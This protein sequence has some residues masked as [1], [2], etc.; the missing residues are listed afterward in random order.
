MKPGGLPRQVRNS[1]VKALIRNGWLFVLFFYLV[2]GCSPGDKVAIKQVTFG[3][4]AMAIRLNRKAL[5]HKIGIWEGKK[6]VA[7]KK[8]GKEAKTF[9]V[10]INW[11]RGKKYRIKV[12]LRRQPLPLVATWQAPERPGPLVL[13]SFDLENVE[14]HQLWD[15]CYIG[16][17]VAISPEAKYLAVGSEKGYLRLVN[18]KNGRLL[19]SKRIGEGRIVSMGFSPDGRYLAMGEQSRDAFIYLYDIA[20]CLIWKF[21]AAR[22][23]GTIRPGEPQSH[24]PVVNALVFTPDGKNW[25]I[26]FTAGHY[27]G[28][29]GRNYR[30]RGRV[31]C[32]DMQGHQLWA[33]PRKGCMDASPDALRIDARGQYLIFSNFWKGKF[34][35]KSLYC[36]DGQSGQLLWNWNSRHFSPENRLGIWHGVDISADGTYVAAFSNDGRGFLLSNRQLIET[37]GKKGVVWEKTISAPIM[38]NGL[39]IYGFPALA[40][41]GKGYVAFLTGNTNARQGRRG[42]VIE[43]PS[44]NS[45]FVYDLKGKLQWTS[46]VGGASYTDRIHTSADGRYI[47][48]PIRYNRVK[49][50]S[51]LHGVYLFDN[52][53]PGSASKK[54]VWFFHTD[55]MS[56]SADISRNGKY[57]ALLEYPVDMDI[58]DEFQD[59]KG[60]HRVY[61]L[62]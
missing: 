44:A 11:Q 26:Y 56:L 37:R 46:R 42:P 14:P 35:N 27:L 33:Y 21:S 13:A 23:V 15:Y 30:H 19:W 10:D 2:A 58:R 1:K 24:L 41:I 47:I 5:V 9:L 32:L 17:I 18:I 29:D 45:L 57:I 28:T 25:K 20:G 51:L 6:E 43:S 22:D 8:I 4:G 12:T 38:V 3:R 61:I 48:L 53:R 59:V 52:S 39:A 62:R 60:K 54:L 40:K 16:G 50:D 55:G 36:L 34:Y 31:Y 7:S 49:E